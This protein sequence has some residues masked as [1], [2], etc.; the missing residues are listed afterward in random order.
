MNFTYPDWWHSH[1][2][3][4]HLNRAETNLEQVTLGSSTTRLIISRNED[5]LNLPWNIQWAVLHFYGET[6]AGNRKVNHETLLTAFGF[7]NGTPQGSEWL[8]NKY[9][10]TCAEQ[11]AFLRYKQFLNIPCPGTGNDGDPNLSLFL[12][13]NI[14][15]AVLNLMPNEYVLK[16]RGQIGKYLLLPST[17]T[18]SKLF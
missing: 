12:D 13:T 15:Q 8:I 17:P 14:Q 1:G 18:G 4:L 16:L 2:M 11:G 3:K 6:A 5:S 7:N 9:G 10:G